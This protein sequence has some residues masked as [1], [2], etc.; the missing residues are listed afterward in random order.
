MLTEA[1]AKQRLDEEG[2][3]EIEEKSRSVFLEFFK[4]FWGP[5]PW[6]IEAALILSLFARDIHDALIIGVLLSINAAVGFQEEHQAGRVL[7]ALKKRLPIQVKV[8]RDGVWKIVPLREIVRGDL[9]HLRLGDIV[10][11]DAKVIEAENMTVDQA[12]LT[13]ESLPQEKRE[14]ALLYSGSIIK[15]GEG[16]AEVVAT[17][18]RSYFGKTAELVSTTVTKSHLQRALLKIGNYL[19]FVALLLA[20]FILTDAYFRHFDLLRILQFVLILTVASIPAAMPTIFSITMALGARAL[21]K[22]EA[23]VS[24]LTAI[25]ELASI[26]LLCCDKTGTLTQNAIRIADL[27]PEEPLSKEDLLIMARLASKEEGRD[28][29]DEAILEGTKAMML[30]Y[31]LHQFI[32]FDPRVK[33]TEAKV[34]YQ[35]KTFSITKGSL[36]SIATLCSVEEHKLSKIQSLSEEMAH[37]GF[38]TLVVAKRED[39]SW[40]F[41]GLIA[42][43]DPPRADSKEMIEEAKGLGIEIKM[44]TGDQLAI[45]REIGH[46]L[47]IG[48]HYVTKN[49]LF[50]KEQSEKEQVELLEKMNGFAEVFPEDKYTIVKLLKAN[51]HHVGVTGDGV[52]DAPALKVADCGIAVSKAL[53]AARSAADIILL[54][55]GLKVIIEA[56]RESRRIFARM[57][58]YATYRIAETM[59]VLFFITLSILVFQ[60][61]PLTAVMV[62]LLA[63]LNDIAIVSIA[64]DRVEESS[65]PERWDIKEMLSLATLLGTIGVISSFLAF[66]YLNSGL[67]MSHDLIRTFMYL[68]LSI[69]GHSTIF[70]TRTKGPF[71]SYRP[72]LILF[73]AVVGTQ[74]I[75][76]LIAMSGL[77]MTPLPF[78]WVVAIWLYCLVWLFINDYAKRL[79]YRRVDF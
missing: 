47:N 2:Y 57:K 70:V 12:A 11:A 1:E 74:L 42:L 37:R 15:T 31:T 61:Y 23:I 18:K 25:Q 5:I 50:H 17:G 66:F 54:K 39:E 53:D 64:Y 65:M 14:G 55:S 46:Q 4:Y 62:I 13:G 45:A 3:N 33:R 77:F 27:Y 78:P 60:F 32:P 58:Y 75:A 29:I 19:I 34:T 72:S 63:V 30:S 69:A 67:H 41:L 48:D 8:K 59:R 36:P 7:E 44:V 24:H 73:S 49:E 16:D 79:F 21:S 35:G 40:Q 10:P 28:P 22:Q 6:M 52:N 68:K 26:D 43:N 56:I 38:R 76:S 20:A 51:G 71:Y 9:I